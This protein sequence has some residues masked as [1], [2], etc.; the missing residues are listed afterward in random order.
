MLVY[1]AEVLDRNR[2]RKGRLMGRSIC[3]FENGTMET[4]HHLFW[5]VHK[6]TGNPPFAALYYHPNYV[7]AIRTVLTSGVSK[8]LS[9]IW[10]VS[11]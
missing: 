4:V 5:L 1:L 10:V 8:K 6:V 7:S 11:S 2:D 3:I 9:V